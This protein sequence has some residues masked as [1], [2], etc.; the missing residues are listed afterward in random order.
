MSI[1]VICVM[2]PTGVGKSAWAIRMARRL[3][4][5][6]SCEIISADSVMVYKGLDVGSAKPPMAERAGVPHHLI[7]IRQVWQNYSAADFRN[8]AIDLIRSLRARGITPLVVGGSM[9]YFYILR[10]GIAPMPDISAKTRMYVQTQADREG[11][12]AMHRRLAKIDPRTAANIHPHHSA[13]IA[14]AMEVYYATGKP[15]SASHAKHLPGL[16]QLGIPTRYTALLPAPW[17]ICA[18]Q[19]ATNPYWRAFDARLRGRVS[20]MLATGLI[21]ECKQALH[22][23]RGCSQQWADIL[24]SLR[25]IGYKQ[26]I[27]YAK[28]QQQSLDE[29]AFN[30]STRQILLDKIMSATTRMVRHQLNWLKRF[31][32]LRRIVL[33][34]NHTLHPTDSARATQ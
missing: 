5:S 23:T 12:V 9:F 24:P 8:E 15:M 18:T 14:R 22:A 26:I 25:A 11:W 7:D 1:P 3:R 20:N 28:A 29:I 4:H 17:P 32:D 2:G 16:E 21:E 33:T 10:H 31:T 34:R 27:E 30:M 13:R 6:K 19:R